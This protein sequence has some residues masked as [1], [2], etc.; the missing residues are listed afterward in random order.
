MDSLTLRRPD[1]WHLHLRDGPGMRDVVAH[2]AARFARAIIMPNL[3]PPVVNVAQALAYRER[4]VQA[5]PAESDFQ[6]LMTLYLTDHTTPEDIAQLAQTPEVIAVKYY[7]AGATTHSEF[8]V[9][10]LRNV[11]PV[12][13]TMQQLGVPLLI[14]GEVTAPSVDIFDR[15]CQFVCHILDPLLE[16]F[17][18]LRVVL[19][20]I[21]TLQAALFVRQGEDRLAATITAH[22]LLMNRNALFH[23]GIRP[24]HY[25][26]PVLKREE[27]RQALVI[28]A[29]C[30]SGRFFAGT[31]S[32]PHAQ[33]AKQSACGCAG[34][35]SAPAALEWYAQ[36]FDQAGA[37][38]RLENFVSV[39]GAQFYG[40]PLNEGQVTLRRNTWTMPSDFAFGAERVVPL[41]SGE[42][43]AWQLDNGL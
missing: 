37:L 8:G 26:L 41:G 34:M 29:T 32:A 1:D 20:H 30:G 38:A 19:E 10:D 16:S 25:C 4:I 28:A 13:E 11:W 14:H 36:V 3:K 27:H 21:T 2:S 39:H 6:P 5:L 31:D 40:L 43:V 22:H 42:P 9:T 18:T 35:F 23:G 24:H 33:T 17:P 15:E 7:P 12:L